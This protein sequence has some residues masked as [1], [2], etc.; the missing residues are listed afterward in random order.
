[1]QLDNGAIDEFQQLYFKEYG[2][3]LTRQ[4]A[5]E[6]GARLIQFVKAVYGKNLPDKKAIEMSV[7]KDDN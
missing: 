4:D 6:L 7:I 3:K 2:I 1:M 5:F